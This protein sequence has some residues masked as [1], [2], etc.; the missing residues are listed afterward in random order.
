MVYMYL[1]VNLKFQK[2]IKCGNCG[3][4]SIFKCGIGGI[5]DNMVW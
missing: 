4:N 1:N 3:G 2:N 5:F